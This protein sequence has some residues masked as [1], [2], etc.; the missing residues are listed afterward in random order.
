MT[1]TT[2]SPHPAASRCPS[3]NA[4]LSH[5]ACSDVS[6]YLGTFPRTRPGF[7]LAPLRSLPRCGHACSCAL[8]LVIFWLA[9]NAAVELGAQ[10]RGHYKGRPT[11]LQVYFLFSS[12]AASTTTADTRKPLLEAVEEMGGLNLGLNGSWLVRLQS[13][14]TV[15][16]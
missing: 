8:H 12:E 14:I 4:F 13:V 11:P 7:T 10:Q 16:R 6:A 5:P 2:H 1:H 9:R 15:Q 3:R